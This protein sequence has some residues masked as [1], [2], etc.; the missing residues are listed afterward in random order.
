MPFYRE[1]QT[2]IRAFG[3]EKKWHLRPSMTQKPG[4]ATP[5]IQL[6]FSQETLVIKYSLT[7]KL[8]F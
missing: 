5:G 3:T 6:Y 1:N 7:K 8:E 2:I 4:R